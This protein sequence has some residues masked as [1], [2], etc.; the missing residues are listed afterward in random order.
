MPP[1]AYPHVNQL[2]DSLLPQLQVVLGDKLV[3]LYLYGSLVWG[4]YDDDISDVDLLAAISGDLD[5]CELDGLKQMHNDLAKRYPRWDNRIEVAYLSLHG[6][7]TFKTQT[8]KLG[9]ISPGEPLHIIDSGKDWQMN[10]YLVREKGVTLYGPPPQTI[11]EPVSRDEFIQAVKEHLVLWREWIL[12]DVYD[13]PFQAYAIL[14]MCRALYVCTHGE[15][16]S[17]I[18]AA[19]WAQKELPEWSPT[20]E[21]ALDWRRASREEGVDHE[22][23]LADTRRFVN[24][25]LDRMLG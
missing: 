6:L 8:S 18:Q 19:A 21:K 15:Q 17:K 12:D 22:A 5:E 24:F 16:V 1:T 23:T 14:L 4:D 9:I 10:W 25:M 13:R 3:G 20:I 7:K 2:L 11:I